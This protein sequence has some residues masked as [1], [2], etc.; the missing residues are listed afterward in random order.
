MP[1]LRNFIQIETQIGE[2]LT[3]GDTTITPQSQALIVHWPH[4]GFVWNRP[5]AVLVE[6]NGQTQRLPIVDVTRYI[7]W[8]FAGLTLMF[9]VIIAVTAHRRGAEA[10]SL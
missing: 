2:P 4:G 10:R 3:V 7:T 1:S 9:S 6:E 8:S 5:V